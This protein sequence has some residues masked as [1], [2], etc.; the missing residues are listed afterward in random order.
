M[1]LTYLRT[2]ASYVK[3]KKVHGNK[4]RLYRRENLTYFKP[5]DVGY[6]IVKH[7]GKV[8]WLIVAESSNI[9]GILQSWIDLGL[10][11]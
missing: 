3:Q 9:Q 4:Y 8:G 5:D 7:D 11:D 2:D 1:R 10:D 6:A